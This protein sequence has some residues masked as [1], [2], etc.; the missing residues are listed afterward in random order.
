MRPAMRALVGAT[1]STL[2][3]SLPADRFD[4]AAAKGADSLE[5]IAVIDP[6]GGRSR[7]VVDIGGILY[8]RI[9]AESSIIRKQPGRGVNIATSIEPVGRHLAAGIDG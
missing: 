3:M 2:T 8:V 6:P 4:I 5:E 7:D 9:R 1:A